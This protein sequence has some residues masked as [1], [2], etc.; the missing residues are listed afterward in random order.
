MKEDISVNT[1]KVR[2]KSYR[3]MA[4]VFTVGKEVIQIICAYGLQG[5]GKNSPLEWDESSITG[6][7]GGRPGPSSHCSLSNRLKSNSKIQWV[8]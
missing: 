3:V 1:V 7:T 2:R 4:I 6:V 8:Y 5:G